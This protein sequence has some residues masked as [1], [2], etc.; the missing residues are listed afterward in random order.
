MTRHKS[1][2]KID[3]PELCTEWNY[4]KNKLLPEDFYKSDSDKVWWVC[5]KNHEWEASIHARVFM[6]NGCPYCANKLAC[7]DNCL[8]TLC[9]ELS[10][11]WNCDKNEL[12]P[13][14]VLPNTKKKV[15]WKC[16]QG[17]EWKAWIGDRTHGTKCTQCEYGY[18]LRDRDAIYSLDGLQKCCKSCNEW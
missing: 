17:H 4:N 10:K 11:E 6:N 9:P 15:W 7:L 3:V 8:E 14:D 13:R 18:V 1:N 2:L 5:S 16:V 12:T